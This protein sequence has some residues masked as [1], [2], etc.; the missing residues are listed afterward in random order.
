MNN[1]VEKLSDNDANKSNNSYKVLILSCGTGGGHNTAAKAIQ[2]E[3]LTQ[4]VQADFK[5]YLE[6]INPK[7]KDKVNNLYIKSTNREGKVF[8]NIYHLG[9]IYEK[10]KLRSPVYILNSLSKQKLYKYI[11]DNEYNYIIT[12]HL[13]A[14]QAL[15]AIKKQHDIHFMQVA[16]DYVSIPFW[17]ETNPDYFVIPSEEL[18]SDFIEKG[19]KK[20]K[21]LPLG[22]PVMKQ[23]RKEY[24]KQETK[25]SLNLDLNKK[26]ILILNGS[27]GFGNVN[28][29]AEKL[30]ENI[31]DFSFIISCGNNNKLKNFLDNKYKDNERIIAL[32][33]TNKLGEYVASSEI[34]LTKPGGLTTTEI[35]T[36]RKPLVHIMPIPGCE[37]YN[38]NFFADRQMSMKCEDINQVINNTKKI[39]ENK[40]LQMEIAENQKK[41]IA[42][43]ACEQ[44]VGTIIKELNRSNI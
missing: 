28:E 37:N 3:L 30:L 43:D 6:I 9:K 20:Q 2:E 18:E 7:L 36:M 29:I 12:T 40:N 33:Y 24:D 15:T 39:I 8:K 11:K 26:Y 4:N 32:P 21:L 13:F 35:A 25:K 41:Y 27:M 19:M 23:Y 34:I 17:K 5:E 1:T 38:A 22:I 31:K 14:A 16:T 10:T 44:I 42:G